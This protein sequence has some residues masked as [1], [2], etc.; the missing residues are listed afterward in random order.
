MIVDVVKYLIIGA[1]GDLDRFFEH[2]QEH[3]FMEFIS[4]TGKKGIEQP[5]TVQSLISAIKILR[6]YSAKEPYLGGGDLAFSMQVS[7]RIIELKDDLE[8]LYEEKRV[9]ET[10]IARVAPFGDFSMEDIEFI[11]KSGKRKIQFFCV[12]TAKSH[13]LNSADEVIYIS[14]EYDLDYFITFNKEHTSYPGMIEMRIDS[15]KGELENRLSFVED[16][17]ARFEGELKDY[18]GYTIFLQGTLIEELNKYH[19]SCAKKEVVY[20]LQNSFFAIETWIPQNRVP[21]LFALMDGLS[22]HAEEVMI[23]KQ[24]KP[25]TCLENKGL[26]EIG[27]DLIKVYDIPAISDKDPSFWVL[28]F[29][30]LFFSIIVADAGYGLVYLGIAAYLKYKFPHVAG[31]KK[32][33]LKLFFI[34]S[35]GCIGWGVLTSSYFGLSLASDNPLNKVSLLHY[36][37][38]KKLEY[39]LAEKDDVYQTWLAKNLPKEEMLDEFSSNIIL[40]TTLIIGIIHISLSFLRYL[41]R[42]IAGLGWIIFMVGGYLFFPKVLSATTIANFMGWISKSKADAVGQ[43]LLYGGIGF[44]I[45]ASLL[46]KGVKKGWSEIANMIQVFA[47]VLSYLRLYALGLAGSIMA[48]TFNEEGLKLGLAVGVLIGV[49]G[50]CINLSLSTMGGVI[51]GLRLNFLEWYHYC[52]DGGGKLFKPLHKIKRSS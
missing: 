16:A 21:S 33:M 1:K 52:F 39:H 25:P 11:E 10:E 9:L 32:R 13:K 23:E 46:Q 4:V 44:A 15:P 20:P 49:A 6:K 24:E 42:N 22:V 35:F 34:L 41:R 5:I 2:A 18:A 14:T 31:I 7:E 29:F 51:H 26:V 8:K 37:A 40:E 30:V 45:I 3:G 36:V 28:C 47:D 50:H 17:I 19:L 27:E 12:K 43:Q 38:E 48:S